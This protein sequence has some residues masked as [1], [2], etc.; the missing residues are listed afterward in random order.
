MKHKFKSEM[1]TSNGRRVSCKHFCR[2]NVMRLLCAATCIFLFATVF[3]M[4]VM[5]EHT[6][7][8][9]HGHDIIFDKKLSYGSDKFKINGEDYVTIIGDGNYYLDNDIISSITLRTT[10]TV[11]L[12]LNG[13]VIQNNSFTSSTVIKVESGTLN[14]YDCPNDI[15]HKFIPTDGD[16]WKWN[17][18]TNDEKA[19]TIIGGVITS[20]LPSDPIDGGGI[21]NNGELNLYGGTIIGNIAQNGGGVYNAEGSQMTLYGGKIIGNRALYG[22]GGI[23][24]HGILKIFGGEISSNSVWYSDTHG[25]GG[26][27]NSSEGSTTIISDGKITENM[28]FVTGGGVYTHEDSVLKL[29]GSINITENIVKSGN[30]NNLYLPSGKTVSINS[31]LKNDAKIGIT[32][33]SKPEEGTNVVISLDNPSDYSKNFI[34]DETGYTASNTIAENLHHAVVLELKQCTVT[35]D[36]LDGSLVPSTTL[37]YGEKV[38]EPTAP[39][40]TGYEFDG[41]YSNDECT[42]PWDFE[43]DVVDDTTL[44][45]KWVPIDYSITNANR[46]D[47]VTT[48]F[49]T[50]D[51]STEPLTETT[52]RYGDCIILSTTASDGYSIAYSVKDASGA[53]VPINGNRFTMPASNVNVFTY[54]YK[55]S[56]TSALPTTESGKIL[57]IGEQEIVLPVSFTLLGGVDAGYWN[58]LVSITKDVGEDGDGGSE[59]PVNGLTYIYQANPELAGTT[60]L[61]SQKADDSRKFMMAGYDVHETGAGTNLFTLTIKN[62]DSLTSGNYNIR[63]TI[64]GGS[65]TNPIVLRD[66]TTNIIITVPEDVTSK[67]DNIFDSDTTEDY[68]E[69]YFDTKPYITYIVHPV[70]GAID[71]IP[72]LKRAALCKYHSPAKLTNY[73]IWKSNG[74]GTEVDWILTTDTKVAFENE[75]FHLRIG[76]TDK[77]AA[78]FKITFD[79]KMV[80]DVIDKPFENDC[81]ELDDVDAILRCIAGD[82]LSRIDDEREIY[83]DVDHDGEINLVDACLLFNYISGYT[84]AGGLPDCVYL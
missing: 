74:I 63:F 45:A 9:G 38:T 70:S 24:N 13:H 2:M 77:T 61:S 21:F 26:G 50:A 12:C 83:C 15:P 72:T 23:D 18:G 78:L 42:N 55:Y 54:L 39:T 52:A 10:G 44:F 32:T 81:L 43:T 84:T 8:E 14:I 49:A 65:T 48:T 22:G 5:A 27:I 80:G 3:V 59:E 41:W 19:V 67:T 51:S 69:W 75:K 47:G 82:G 25:I 1:M 66:A 64:T 34:P 35:F 71:D 31:I 68:R 53:D 11:N 40:K 57:L 30:A 6:H 33:E 79:G 16:Q 56:V 17:N 36:S 29:S 28:A 7:E 58:V 62:T 46:L 76:N 60:T 20:H 73:T 37:N 4:P